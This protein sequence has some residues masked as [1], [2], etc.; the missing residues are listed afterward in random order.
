M[1]VGE[2]FEYGSLQGPFRFALCRGCN[3]MALTFRLDRSQLKQI[4]PPTYYTVNPASPLFLKGFIYEKKIQMDAA[5]AA[6]FIQGK[7]V[8]SILDVGA[9]DCERLIYLKHHLDI[10]R[11]KLTGLDIQFNDK[12]INRAR[13]EGILLIESD[14][15]SLS[16]QKEEYDMIFMSQLLE[17]LFSPRDALNRL[18]GVLN[19]NGTI[20]VE[21]P[22]WKSLDFL[23]FKKRYWGG[24]HFPR[25]FNIFS[26]ESLCELVQSC[27]FMVVKQGF[28]PSPGFWIISLR[29]L[30]GLS[31]RMFSKSVFEFINF[32]SLPVVGLFTL[33]DRFTILLRGKTSNQ[34][35]AAEKPG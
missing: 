32:S 10:P 15:E 7:S 28:L 19:P 14:V 29:N 3:H 33:I 17:H 13:R 18:Y 16:M 23:L 30:L 25:H 6:R 2:D 21:T 4:Y 27:G 26:P 12:I 8:R 5:R 22:N 20:I 34:F 31:S 11:L 35:L 9:G 24:Y 1:G